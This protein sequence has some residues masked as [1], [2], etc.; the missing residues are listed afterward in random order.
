MRILHG[1]SIRPVCTNRYPAALV[2]EGGE[3]ALPERSK[4]NRG[5]I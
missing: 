5:K 2:G 1:R 3:R 4:K